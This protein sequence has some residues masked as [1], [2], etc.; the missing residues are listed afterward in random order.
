MK[1]ETHIARILNSDGSHALKVL[2]LGNLVLRCY[3]SSPNQ[4]LAQAARDALAA[5]YRIE[6][7]STIPDPEA[8]RAIV[9]LIADLPYPYL[10]VL[11][12]AITKRCEQLST[13]NQEDEA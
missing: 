3:P 1:V 10:A 4:K 13:P 6:G 11:Q 2:K 8:F 9:E 7:M 5:I 12:E